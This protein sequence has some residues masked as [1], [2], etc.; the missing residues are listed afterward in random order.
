[1][2]PR[3]RE[4][5]LNVFLGQLLAAQHPSWGEEKK[6][7]HIES[8]QA[9]REHMDSSIDILV[10]SPGKQPVA[11]EAKF[12]SG[13]AAPR[14]QVEDRMGLTVDE[15]GNVIEAGISV[16][17]PSQDLSKSD[18]AEATLRYAVHQLAKDDR[19]VR[20]PE[21]DDEWIE[22]TV[23]DLADAV[24]IV[25]LSE[26]GSGKGKKSSLMAFGTQAPDSKPI[27]RMQRSAP[28]WRR[29][30]TRRRVNKPLEWR[31]PSS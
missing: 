24:D 31:S 19:V 2:P 15:S 4:E 21:G 23:I 7:L 1:M 29:F 10:D 30:C 8:R 18:L 27:V 16:V 26:S 13:R 6:V 20:W 9:I 25:S 3:K 11:I 17:Y 28:T 12:E 5:A 14:R 22:G